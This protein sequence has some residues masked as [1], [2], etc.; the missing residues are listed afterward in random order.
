MNDSRRGFLRTSIAASAVATAAAGLPDPALA[1]ATGARPASPTMAR[2]MTL[3]NMRKDG[4][5]VLGV[6]TAKGIL[7]VARA[8]ARFQA[9]APRVTDDVI[10]GGDQGLGA[11]VAR[12]LA[13]GPA[14]LFADESRIEFAGAIL[15]PQKIVCVGLNYARHARE[16]NNPIPKLPILFNKFNNTLNTHKGAVRVSTVPATQFDYE[17]EL[18]IVMGRRALTS[19]RPTPCSTRWAMPRATT[20]PRATCSRAAASG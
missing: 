5:V 11:L 10:Q 14:E 6:K 20:S 8:A 4:D 18:V 19:A 16:T 17:A 9:S 12:A 3:L 7:D 13:T 2:A 1:Q 15:R